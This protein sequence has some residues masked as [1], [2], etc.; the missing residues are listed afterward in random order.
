MTSQIYTERLQA[1][2]AQMDAHNIDAW[3]IGEKRKPVH[4]PE[5]MSV[6]VADPSL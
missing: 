3:V 2:R 6:Y 5:N 4:V 1:L